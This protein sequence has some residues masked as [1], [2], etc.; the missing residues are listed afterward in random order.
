MTATA[1][2]RISSGGRDSYADVVKVVTP[3]V[4]T[5]RTEGRAR[6]S[7]TQFQ[8]DD[9]LRR[10]FGDQFGNGQRRTPAPRSRGLGSG[11]V[12]SSDGYLL[13]NH[14]VIDNATDIRVEFAD[15]RRFAAKLIGIGS[16]ER[17]RAA[18]DR[19]HEPAAADARRLGRGA[20]R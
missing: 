1:P 5:I 11:V 16:A 14:H 20:G 17:S 4:V 12:V 13:T 7:P 6:V 10:F 9:L 2:A 15:G 3:A 18:E 8:D 19:G